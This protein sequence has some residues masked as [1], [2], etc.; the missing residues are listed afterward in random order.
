MC[1][2]ASPLTEWGKGENAPPVHSKVL[3]DDYTH[4]RGL[5]QLDR[6][7]GRAYHSGIGH[8]HMIGNLRYFLLQ[9]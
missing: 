5:Q 2:L 8:S 3:P 7:R 1:Q 9:F 4:Q 6:R